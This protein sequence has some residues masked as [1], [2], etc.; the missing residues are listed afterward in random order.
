MNTLNTR[1]FVHI[2]LLIS[3]LLSLVPA[4]M[5]L[6][7]HSTVEIIDK[8]ILFSTAFGITIANLFLQFKLHHKSFS[9]FKIISYTTLCNVFLFILNLAIRVPFWQS[10]PFRKPPLSVFI[11]VDVVRHIIIALVAFWAVSYLLKSTTAIINTIKVKELENQALQLQLKNL[12]AQLQPHFFF[13][14]LN[15]LSEL[16]HID[17]QKSDTYIKNLSDIF[18]YVLSNQESTL[19]DVQDEIK[20]IKSYLYLLEIRFEN[21]LQIEFII[22]HDSNYSIP[23]LCT[24]SV[25]ENIIKHNTIDTMFIHISLSQVKQS[26]IIRNSKKIKKRIQV[27]SLGFGLVNIENKCQLLLQRRI[28][29]NETN[30]FYEIEIPLS[31][32]P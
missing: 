18:R 16:I 5:L 28:Q 14:N 26:L 10:I 24:L 30:D 27:E 17:V 9:V 3:I 1:T 6:E 4:F 32:K 7:H 22:P 29:I 23:S 20:F 31:T 12:S 19:I 2:A 13:N 11:A 8:V 15:V 21:A 25:L